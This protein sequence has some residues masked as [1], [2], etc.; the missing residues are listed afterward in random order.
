VGARLEDGVAVRARAGGAGDPVTDR[1]VD[2]GVGRD[3]DVYGLG[4][5]LGG[6]GRGTVVG[7]ERGAPYDASPIVSTASASA[8]PGWS[9]SAPARRLS[10][11]KR[12]ISSRPVGIGWSSRSKELTGCRWLSTW[13]ASRAEATASRASAVT[14]TWELSS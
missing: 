5:V 12:Q 2:L 14:V 1:L 9:S 3:P 6:Q 4:G 8:S 13:S 7:D 10:G 11:V